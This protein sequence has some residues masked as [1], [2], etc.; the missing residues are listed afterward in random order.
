M[1][2]NEEDSERD[3]F[4]KQGQLPSNLNE[5]RSKHQLFVCTI[6]NKIVLLHLSPQLGEVYIHEL[7]PNMSFKYSN[8]ISLPKGDVLYQMQLVDNMI[9][10][11]NI[12]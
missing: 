4:S 7:D 6:Y 12:D 11:H 5:K 1:Q 9:A 8:S 3:S 10:I 2:K